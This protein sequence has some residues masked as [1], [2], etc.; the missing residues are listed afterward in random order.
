MDQFVLTFFIFRI[1]RNK[2]NNFIAELPTLSNN[3]YQCGLYLTSRQ[4]LIK[5]IMSSK[6]VNIDAIPN[7][8]LKLYAELIVDHILSFINVSSMYYD[9]S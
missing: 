4:Y 9:G 7:Y 2:I 8:V 1:F 5:L 3:D 6:S